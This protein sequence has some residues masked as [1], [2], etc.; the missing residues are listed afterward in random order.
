MHVKVEHFCRLQPGVADVVGV[1]YPGH[2]LALDSP[3]LFDISIDISQYLTRMVF[4]G[5]AVDDRYARV[6]GKTLDDVLLK[7][8]D[9]DQ[10][11]HARNDLRGVFHRLAAAQ[12]RVARVEVDGVAAELLHTCFKRQARARGAFLENHHQG[13]IG[14]RMIRL[15]GLEALLDNARALENMLQLGT[16]QV[17]KLQKMFDVHVMRLA[18][19]SR[20][21]AGTAY[22]AIAVPLLA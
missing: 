9:H 12:L 15:V 6:G 5:Q 16:A 3:A 2:G 19:G 8:A 17:V 14:Q 4:I 1:A 22:P 13:A 21:A 20:Q 11:A 18:P 10:V 7:G